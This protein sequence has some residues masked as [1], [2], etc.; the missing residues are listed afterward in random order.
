LHLSVWVLEI[1]SLDVHIGYYQSWTLLAAMSLQPG[2][3]ENY[4]HKLYLWLEMNEMSL[5]SLPP[6]VVD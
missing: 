1:L 2:N 6:V 5:S 3:Q 4:S